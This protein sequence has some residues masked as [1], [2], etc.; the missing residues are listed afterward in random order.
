MVFRFA[1]ECDIC[2]YVFMTIYEKSK[3]GIAVN[4]VLVTSAFG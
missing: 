4:C 3:K 1:L 2:G